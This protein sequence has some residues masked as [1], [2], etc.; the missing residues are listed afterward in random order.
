MRRLAVCL[1][2]L[3]VLSS[4]LSGRSALSPVAAAP[5]LP[6]PVPTSSNCEALADVNR[7]GIVDLYDLARI[8]RAY[9]PQHPASDTYADLNGDGQ[10]DLFDLVLFATCDG[11]SAREGPAATLRPYAPTQPP[12]PMPVAIPVATGCCKH[13]VKG[14]PCGDTCIARSKTCH[15][16]AGC[17]CY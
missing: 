13:C 14:K 2:I 1:A 16:P 5:P 11:A 6:G 10:V 17:A 12:T 15:K 9:N 4:G 8:A 3:C 7:D